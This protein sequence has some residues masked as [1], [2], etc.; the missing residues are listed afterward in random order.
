VAKAD[1]LRDVHFHSLELQSRARFNGADDGQD[2]I[3]WMQ[4]EQSR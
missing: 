2:I 3:R 4:A 1:R